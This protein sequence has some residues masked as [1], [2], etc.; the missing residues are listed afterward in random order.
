MKTTRTRTTAGLIYPIA[1]A[2]MSFVIGTL[3]VVETKHVRIWDEV[4]GQS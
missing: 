2:L 4:G 1:I 3:F